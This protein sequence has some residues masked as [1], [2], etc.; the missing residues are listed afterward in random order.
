MIQLRPYQQQSVDE[1]RTAFRTNR[2]VLLQG[3]TGSGKTVIFA[4]I[5]SGVHRKGKRA[6]ILVHRRELVD[7]T[8]AQLA[9]MGIPHG[10][11][12]PDYRASPMLAIQVAAIQTV[13]RRG[14]DLAADLMIADESHHAASVSWAK[15]LTA[16]KG[17]LLGVTAT[18]ERLDGKGLDHIFEHMV[19]GPPV[20][21]LIDAGY[22]ADYIAYSH[23]PDTDKLARIKKLA[24]DY[25]AD[26]LGSLMSEH[27][28]VGDAIDHYRQYIQPRSA[29]LFSPTVA[30][31][32]LM[33]DAFR[34]EGYRAAAI[35]GKLSRQDRKEMTS[36]FATGQLD[37]LT[38]C[39][40][41]SEGFDI[42]E[43]G[44][45]IH[46]RPTASLALHLQQIG[47]ALR[48]KRDKSR[49]VI[50]DH[51]GN[52]VRHQMP[53]W[54]RE[55]RLTGAKDRIAA[56]Q[57]RDEVNGSGGALSKPDCPYT[58]IDG[59]LIEMQRHS[60]NWLLA[61]G[62]YHAALVACETR[63]DLELMGA[64]RG[65]KKR[66]AGG[67]WRYRMASKEPDPTKRLILTR[68]Y[69]EALAGCGSQD[70][71]KFMQES[72]GYPDTWFHMQRHAKAL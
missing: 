17:K 26:Q 14:L 42:P 34:Q 30:H 38:S 18:P 72:W 49:A 27:V 44:G 53:D 48:P 25:R 51:A 39:D 31:A 8:S 58:I 29:I 47:R 71:L 28:I 40:L 9:G 6:T 62:A 16:H 1:I 70:D 3:A 21:E 36:G 24:G 11:I 4:Y 2:S 5:A 13:S 68:A 41:I 20:R 57:A 43:A 45:T 59:Q 67:Q 15:V 10:V 65:Y 60:K 66:W 63:E 35:H 52:L 32:E 12:S 61:H 56:E 54:P 23:P 64:L 69:K 37:V 7:Q 22:L 33:A 55:W 50:L 46:M 19:L